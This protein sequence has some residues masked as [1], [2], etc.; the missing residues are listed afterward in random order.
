MDEPYV[1]VLIV[2]IKFITPLD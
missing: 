1:F 2:F